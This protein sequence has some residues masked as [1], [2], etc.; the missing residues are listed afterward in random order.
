MT[1]TP[2]STPLPSETDLSHQIRF[3]VRALVVFTVP[4]WALALWYTEASNV[5]LVWCCAI[6][7]SAYLGFEVFLALRRAEARRARI[8]AE[9]V[10]AY[11]TG[12]DYR[13]TDAAE[14]IPTN[15]DLDP[16]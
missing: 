6:E 12:R 2:R 13:R 14:Q 7:L 9:E 11:R 15:P 16:V 4:L 5:R 3:A 8:V 1:P 10:D